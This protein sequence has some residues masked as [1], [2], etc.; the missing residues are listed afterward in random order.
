M[1][2]QAPAI[3]SKRLLAVAV[4]LGLVVVVIYNVHVDR[5]RKAGRGRMIELLVRAARWRLNRASR[6]IH[7][8][9]STAD[10]FR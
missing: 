9:W 5:V 8:A 10:R 1:A 4:I 3:Q 6:S 7:T 2:E